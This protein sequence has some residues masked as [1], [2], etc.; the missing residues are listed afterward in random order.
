MKRVHFLSNTDP[1]PTY[2]LAPV[3]ANRRRLRDRGYVVRVFDRPSAR[4]LDC[5]I[6]CLVSKPT[7]RIVGG[8]VTGPVYGPEDPVIRLLERA[9][10]RAGR[11]VW[12]DDSDSTS[13]PR[14]EVL[15]YVDRY[16]KKQLFRDR[17]LYRRTLYGGRLFTDLYHRE[18]GVEDTTP[19][20]TVAPLPEDQEHK[21]GLSWHIGL[22]DLLNAFGPKSLLQRRLPALFK[23]DYDVSFVPPGRPRPVDLFLRTSAG[24]GRETVSFQ[25][26]ETLRRLAAMIEEDARLSGMA[27]DTVAARS[28]EAAAILPETGGRVPRARFKRIMA[29]TR[30]MPSPFGWGEIG[31]RDFEAFA[32]GAMLLKPDMTHMETWP[33][34]F[35]AG[36]TYLPLRWDFSDFEETVRRALED[37]ELRLRLAEG[38]QEAYRAS[39]SAEGMAA[40]CDW[41]VRQIGG[42]G[43]GT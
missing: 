30:V 23:A 32:N 28:T 36:E 31:A 19:F 8:G 1:I 42:E 24:L 35:R 10:G 7:H 6:L 22:G 40:F 43:D 14:F 4:C 27:G 15:P 21:L 5:D 18:F 16:L 29:A 34:I 26:R 20:Q 9:R 12:L 11:I 13:V 2:A 41:F 38:G 39:I 37:D 33:D 25:R 3:R 17:S